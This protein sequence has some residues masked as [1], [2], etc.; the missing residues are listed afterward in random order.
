VDTSPDAYRER[1]LALKA[2]AKAWAESRPKAVATTNPP[3][4]PDELVLARETIPGGWYW[5]AKIQRGTT[6]R[7]ID[8]SGTASVSALFWN[9]DDT[10]ERFNAADTLKVQWTAKLTKGRLLLSDMGRAMVSI[11]D[12]TAAGDHDGLV[13]GSS[14]ATNLAKYG[15]PALRNTRENFLLAAAKLGMGPR[16]IPPCVTFFAPVKIADDSGAFSWRPGASGPGRYIDLRAE[17]N[18]LVTLSNCPHP[19]DPAPTYAP[20]AI[21]AAIWQSPPP[22]P[23]DY[24]RTATEEAIRAFENTDPL[25]AQPG[26]TA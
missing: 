17:M 24:C 26:D 2:R 6:L 3:I 5:S 15:Q 12:D 19:L 1:Y 11:T 25:F 14:A 22:A 13:G 10:S 9:A 16:D 7:I 8:P 21:E 18:L 4:L 23:D 20:A